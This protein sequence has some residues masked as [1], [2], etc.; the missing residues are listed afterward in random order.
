M[1]DQLSEW[2]APLLE[3]CTKRI[4]VE[5]K[6]EGIELSDIAGCYPG[7]DSFISED[8]SPGD[9]EPVTVPQP[10]VV[11]G[12]RNGCKLA[13]LKKINRIKPVIFAVMI[14]EIKKNKS[15]QLL[16]DNADLMG[17]SREFSYRF[18]KNFKEIRRGN[19]KGD[20]DPLTASWRSE[21][22]FYYR[23][24]QQVLHNDP[25]T[26]DKVFGKDIACYTYSDGDPPM[27]PYC[28]DNEEMLQCRTWGMVE[29]PPVKQGEK[30]PLARKMHMLRIARFYYD[31]VE[32]AIS[33]PCYIPVKGVVNY[34]FDYYPDHFSQKREQLATKKD[35]EGE[36]IPIESLSKTLVEDVNFKDNKSTLN[37]E[38][39]FAAARD[40]AGKMSDNEKVAFLMESRGYP[41]KT[42]AGELGY[43]SPASA[44]NSLDSAKEHF[45]RHWVIWGTERDTDPDLLKV[46]FDA[47]I[48][49][50]AGECRINA[51]EE[52]IPQQNEEL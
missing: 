15:L 24:M 35:K 26:K 34:I 43:S 33:T 8:N 30:S 52:L 39:T 7:E 4:A 44:K 19:A 50:C 2:I 17:F 11:E 22:H 3:E 1:V 31:E 20:D 47:V 16:I 18:L 10:D 27:L 49:Y 13:E 45:R 28:Y 36:I 21:Y 6:R 32:K 48:E 12:K 46:Y 9:D 51:S 25:A 42:I 37:R 29:V 41:L 23:H 5:A 40:C 38:E 14:A